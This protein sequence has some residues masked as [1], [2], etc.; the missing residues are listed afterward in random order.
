MAMDAIDLGLLALYLIIKQRRKQKKQM[1]RYYIRPPHASKFALKYGMEMFDR[2]YRSEDSEDL[3]SFC[4]FSPR[5]FDRLLQMVE[6][7]LKHPSTHIRPILPRYRLAIFLRHM[8]HGIS[9][10][11]LQHE[12]AIGVQTAL[13][14]CEEVA[15]FLIDV[16]D[17]M[18]LPIP[19][20]EDWL[21]N[22]RD[23]N[24]RYGFPHVIGA[25]DGK[26]V[27]RTRPD[28]S[29]DL[30]WC[31]K[32]FHSQVLLA[33]CDAHCR[34][35]AVDIGASGRQS[36]SG[37]YTSSQIRR[38]LESAEAGVPAAVP[39]GVIG[40]MPYVV[41]ADGGFGLRDYMMTPLQKNQQQALIG[42]STTPFFQRMPLYLLSAVILEYFRARHVVESAFGQLV[43]RFRI[44]LGPIDVS[45]EQATRL[46]HAAVLL[47]NY[48]GP[49]REPVDDAVQA[50]VRGMSPRMTP[51]NTTEAGKHLLSSA[52]DYKI[53]AESPK[54]KIEPLD[55]KQKSK[56][57]DLVK[58]RPSIW[59]P[60]DRGYL[61]DAGKWLELAKQ[62]NE[63]EL[64][65]YTAK[66]L[67]DFW[68]SLVVYHNRIKN[69][70][71]K[72]SGSGAD[73]KETPIKWVHFESMGFLRDKP[74]KEQ[75]YSNLSQSTAEAEESSDKEQATAIFQRQFR[76]CLSISQL[77]IPQRGIGIILSSRLEPG[78]H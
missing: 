24:E 50:A 16:L 26:H 10:V 49:L 51:R 71:K 55:E 12:F 73:E 69:N 20:T 8:A 29:G 76:T 7:K 33:L 59:N 54:V 23:F 66:N 58:Q 47:H 15:K 6:D 1:R 32:G 19:T 74:T 4:R 64:T 68:N 11:A 39:L 31:F 38:F 46:I 42:F 72:L 53:V 34:F 65:N 56:L 52:M 21:S 3:R 5:R 67:K 62:Y 41:L 27:A 37:L 35:L 61:K 60:A 18:Y 22:A 13:E 14:I 78:Q 70:S 45:T 75:R 44:F 43:Q 30:F 2:Y 48:L 25:I 9:Y 28:E 77:K 57:I 17:P 63:K 40:P 36:D